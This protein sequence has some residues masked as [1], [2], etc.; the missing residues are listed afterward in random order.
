M[1]DTTDI[2]T[3]ARSGGLRRNSGSLTP[4]ARTVLQR[5]QTAQVVA[6]RSGKRRSAELAAI[7][8]NIKK[9]GWL[10]VVCVVFLA[11]IADL[12]SLAD[13]GWVVSWTI[14]I[15]SWFMVRRING[16][17]KSSERIANATN[18]LVR[19]TAIIRQ[20]VLQLLP[21]AERGKLIA[22]ERVGVISEK[23]RS[24]VRTWIRDSVITQL[25]ELIPVVDMLPLYLGQIVKMI[26]NQ[27]IEYQK[28]RKLMPAYERALA[29]ATELEQAEIAQLDRLLATLLGRNY[30]PTPSSEM[31]QE[32][33]PAQKQVRVPARPMRD[34]NRTVALPAAA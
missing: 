17:M 34:I 22:T 31:I 19:E 11:A 33:L 25:I 9:T 23:A 20:R 15:V 21:P 16:I 7:R 8:R 3:N 5:M 28:V 32:P 12:L 14:P 29:Q 30:A 1:A 4:N 27:N 26:V 2:K 13:L 10:V 6:D 18:A 24:Y